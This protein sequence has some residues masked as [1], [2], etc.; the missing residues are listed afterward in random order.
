MFGETPLK[1]RDAVAIK[2]IDNL[3]EKLLS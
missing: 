3:C 1:Y 2:A